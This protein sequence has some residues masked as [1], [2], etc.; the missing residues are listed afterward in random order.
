MQIVQRITYWVLAP[1]LYSLSLLPFYILHRIAEGLAFFLNRIIGYR[2]NMIDRYLE[3][4]FPDQSPSERKLIRNAFYLNLCDVIVETIKS[5]TL[6]PA[7]IRKRFQVVNIEALTQFDKKNQSAF[8]VCGHY[9]NWE[10]MASLGLQFNQAYP[11]LIYTPLQ[12]PYFDKFIQRI[13]K[14]YRVLL[15]SRKETITTLHREEKKGIARVYG[16]AM[17]QSPNP[18]PKSYWRSFLGIRVPVFT[19]AERLAKEYNIPLVYA[20]I[21]RIKRGYYTVEFEVLEENP[22]TTQDYE[23][24]DRFYQKLETQIYADPAQYLWSHKRFKHEGKE[25]IPTNQSKS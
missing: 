3:R 18:K 8:I 22:A 21:N 17:D 5:I 12:N 4:I 20:S 25:F 2:K 23:L 14:K 16:F 7:A 19:G 15:L 11:Y 24:T 9:S 10:W 1:I 6:S 13:R